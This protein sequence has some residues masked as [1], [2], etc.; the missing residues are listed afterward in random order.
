MTRF[1][2]S[3]GRTFEFIGIIFTSISVLL[4]G[5]GGSMAAPMFFVMLG[6]VWFVVGWL[7]VK[8]SIAKLTLQEKE[9]KSDKSF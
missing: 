3:I 7:I 4:F 9:K 2:Y 8:N 1:F 5:K 6:G